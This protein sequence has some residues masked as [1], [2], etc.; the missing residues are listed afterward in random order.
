MATI[1][2]RTLRRAAEIVG[3]AEALALQLEVS[4]ADLATWLAGTGTVPQEVFLR[5][6]DIVTAHQ[7][8]EVSGQHP[9]LKNTKRPA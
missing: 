2:V 5:A 8:S 7:I 9:N 4:S 1:Y 6:V 3:G